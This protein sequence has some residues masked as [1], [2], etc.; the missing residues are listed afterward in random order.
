MALPS[1]SN[2]VEQLLGSFLPKGHPIGKFCWG[3]S[4]SLSEPIGPS[5]PILHKAAHIFRN[6]HYSAHRMTVAVQVSLINLNEYLLK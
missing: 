5:D 1:D 4:K 6:R 2:R 3:N